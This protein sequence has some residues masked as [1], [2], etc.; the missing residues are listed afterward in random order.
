[1]IRLALACLLA[2]SVSFGAWAQPAAKKVADESNRAKA[3]KLLEAADEITATVSRLRGL[4]LKRKFK[5]DVMSKPE[6]RARILQRVDEDLEPG[7]IEGEELTLKRLG[8]I[9]ADSDYKS[10][11]IDLLTDQ[12]AGFYDPKTKE[13]YIADWIDESLQRPVLAHEIDHALQDQSFNLT[14]LIRPIKDNG[15]AQLA[16]QALVEGDGLA[17]M[18][19]FS[20]AEMNIEQDPWAEPAMATLLTQQ[21]Q[22]SALGEMADAPLVIRESLLFPYLGGLGLVAH[23]RRG[24]PWSR[25]DAMYKNPPAST[26]QV[27]H[28]EKYFA[29]ELPRRVILRSIRA[30]RGHEQLL[31][32]VL[33][34]LGFRIFLQHH[35]VPLEDALTAAAGW[36]GDRYAVYAPKQQGKAAA[37]DAILLGR[38]TWDTKEDGA[39]AFSALGRALGALTGDERCK[40]TKQRVQCTDSSGDVSFLERKNNTEL[41]LAIG[42]P[43][44]TANKLPKQLWRRTKVR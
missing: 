12:I 33:G 39:E 21:V 32:N 28:P 40:R 13:L 44:D 27:I 19:E 2:A 23:A 36:G 3:Q 26:E 5:R 1:M 29:G 10:L 18:I 11:V 20:L 16:R 30:M 15:D 9:P 25:V 34:E 14:R 31:D 6:V 41:V 35:G 22:K 37:T 7:L 8:L 38:S 24:Q 43:P 4:P 42:V 17:L